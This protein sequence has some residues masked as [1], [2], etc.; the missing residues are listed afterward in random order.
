[1]M[2]M[3]GIDLVHILYL[4]AIESSPTHICVIFIKSSVIF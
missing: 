1:M 3:N 2:S 4:K